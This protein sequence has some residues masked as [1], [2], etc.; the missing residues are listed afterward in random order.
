MRRL[1]IFA[2]AATLLFTLGL[3]AGVAEAFPEEGSVGQPAPDDLEG[4]ITR[5]QFMDRSDDL[6]EGWYTIMPYRGDFGGDPY[7][8]DGWIINVDLN[9][10]GMAGLYIIVHESDPRWSEDLEPIWGSW[11]IFKAVS[12]GRP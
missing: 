4:T 11:A 8:D 7:L 3:T 1:T 5:V 12:A 2:L 6:G 9:K 10:E